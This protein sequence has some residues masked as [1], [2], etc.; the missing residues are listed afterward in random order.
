LTPALESTCPGS[1]AM[2]ATRVYPVSEVTGYLRD[3]L[4]A[5]PV[6][7]DIWVS[8]EVSNLARPGSGHAYFSLR[9][10][11]ATLRCAMFK[12]SGTGADLLDNGAAVIAHGKVSIYPARGE[13][14][15]VVD[16]VQPEGVGELQ[17]R[18]EELKARL[19]REGLFEN[20]RKRPIPRFPQKVAV[21]TSP[22]G[23]V[24]HDIQNVIGRRYP[25][26]ELLLAPT[27]VQGDAAAAGIAEALAAAGGRG[28]VV[29]L[30]RG[31][32]SAEDLWPFNEEVV[33]RA[34]FSSTVPVISAVGHETDV[35][36]S[37]WVADVRAPTPSAAA[38]MAVPDL[39]EIMASVAAMIRAADGAATGALSGARL[40]LQG[41]D[42]RLVRAVPDMDSMR[43]RVDELLG[44][45]AAHL[46]SAVTSSGAHVAGL[47]ARLETLSPVGT[48]ARGYAI[49]Q[50]GQHGAVVSDAA[51]LASGDAATV[52][53]ARGGFEAEVVTVTEPK[54]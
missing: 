23:A 29:I 12:Y 46:R 7:S 10:E 49:V 38:E 28:D 43:M 47:S 19:E 54:T 33:A 8:G 31:G 41:L 36:I 11:D 25:L 34:V 35:S 27:P 5:D 2:T 4:G 22:T 1:D 21:V 26:V 42:A 17:L 14:Q 50:A 48:L 40:G 20:S 45:A 52:T 37:D 32:G 44:T 51:D 18:F 16:L 3:L 39:R 15:L 24:W 30:A 9:D 53:L 6:V 13:L